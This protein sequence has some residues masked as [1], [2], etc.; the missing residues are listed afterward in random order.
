MLRATCQ[1]NGNWENST[2]P[3]KQKPL[4][5]SWWNFAWVTRS[6][7]RGSVPKMAEISSRGVGPPYMPYETALWV[8]W[9]FTFLFFY[10]RIHAQ[11]KRLNRFWRLM[12]QTTRFHPRTCLLGVWFVPDHIRGSLSPKNRPKKAVKWDFQAKR[13]QLTAIQNSWTDF[14]V[15]CLKRCCFSEGWAFWGLYQHR[16]T[17]RGYCPQKPPQKAFKWDF[18]AKT[19]LL[20]NRHNFWPHKAIAAKL[21]RNI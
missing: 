7:G 21:C 20:Q 2:P 14:D 5:I 6:T 4:E 15:W 9:F 10:S 16:I 12:A 19:T 18:Q 11:P 1:V 3:T 8:F 17:F 13:R